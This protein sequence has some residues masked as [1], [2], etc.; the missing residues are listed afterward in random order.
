MHIT[1]IVELPYVNR[2]HVGVAFPCTPAL[3]KQLEWLCHH[4]FLYYSTLDF[5]DPVPFLHTNHTRKT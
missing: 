4:V 3:Q 5:V 2:S 1:G